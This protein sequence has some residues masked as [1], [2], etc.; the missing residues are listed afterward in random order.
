MCRHIK[1]QALR[2]RYKQ[3]RS[4]S[5]SFFCRDGFSIKHQYIDI[6]TIYLAYERWFCWRYVF[7]AE[8]IWQWMSKGT[9]QV[10][11][12][13]FCRA[14]PYTQRDNCFRCLAILDPSVQVLVYIYIVRP[15]IIRT[16]RKTTELTLAELN[17][18]PIVTA[19]DEDHFSN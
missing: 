10:R 5:Y 2:S 4:R 11:F 17:S 18:P 19:S 13:L 7:I 3:P 9:S 1:C 6:S 12:V 15:A 14:W 16:Q 8:Q